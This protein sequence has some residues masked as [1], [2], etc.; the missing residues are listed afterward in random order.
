MA[1]IKWSE[2]L[3]LG[4]KEVDDQHRKF[5]ELVNQLCTAMKEKKAQ[6]VQSEIIDKLLCYAFY[7]FTKEE[8]LLNKSNYPGLRPHMR[9]HE[10]FVDKISQFK[11]DFDNNKITLS[12]DMI[13]FMRNW[14]VNHIKVSDRKY[15]PYINEEEITH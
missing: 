13:Q 5:L 11:Q 3:N 7:H 14:W 6:T 4:I 8:R 10:A 2:S 12:I 15:M 1:T 9:E